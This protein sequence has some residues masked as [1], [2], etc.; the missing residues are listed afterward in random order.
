[1]ADIRV[2]TFL[3]PNMLRVYQAIAVGPSTIQPVAVSKRF[4][5]DFRDSVRDVLVGFD[6]TSEGREILALGT[7][8]KWVD[9]GPWGYDDIRRMVEA[10]EAAGFMEIR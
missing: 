8:T 7:V 10:C 4:D 3:A 1:M 6:G 5:K 2:G 9:V